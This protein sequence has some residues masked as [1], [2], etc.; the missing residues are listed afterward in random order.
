META[1]F[2]KVLRQ[3]R[4]KFNTNFFMEPEIKTNDRNQNPLFYKMT[5]A[6][7]R[8]SV[9]LFPDTSSNP[10]PIVTLLS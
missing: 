3:G 5:R 10:D 9:L 7:S 1:L 4:K 6:C 8:T 2:L